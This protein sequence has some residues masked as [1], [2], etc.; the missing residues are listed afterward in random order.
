M[1]KFEV[2]RLEEKYPEE[3]TTPSP[4]LPTEKEQWDLWGWAQVECCGKSSRQ[5]RA[6]AT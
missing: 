4:S 1:W 3:R 5:S 2:K 6:V